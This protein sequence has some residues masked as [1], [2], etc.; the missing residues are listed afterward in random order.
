MNKSDRVSLDS[1]PTV[2]EMRARPRPCPKPSARVV[3]KAAKDKSTDKAWEDCKA[4]VWKRD[5]G[6]CRS[7]GRVVVK[8]I[9]LVPQR[10]EVHHITRR[11]KAKALLTDQRNCVLVCLHPC[12][13]QLTHHETDVIGTA[14]QVFTGPD[15][16]TYLDASYPLKFI[17][18]ESV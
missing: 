4:E 10:G 3:A 12:H 5:H 17:K 9:E 6:K 15:G 18:K 7:C 2:A 14:R 8:T 11:V 13:E 16:K 1:L